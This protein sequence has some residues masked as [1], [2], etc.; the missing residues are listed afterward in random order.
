MRIIAHQL[1]AAQAVI[2]E[3]V[4]DLIGLHAVVVRASVIVV[5][6]VRHVSIAIQHDVV[7]R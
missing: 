2:F 1:R 3:S 4:D 5:V 7:C 6:V